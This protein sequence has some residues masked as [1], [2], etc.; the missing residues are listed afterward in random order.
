MLCDA[1]MWLHFPVSL[2]GQKWCL[3]HQPLYLFPRH[4]EEGKAK[5]EH[6]LVGSSVLEEIS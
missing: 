2:C 1:I 3:L 6:L 5:D 4:E